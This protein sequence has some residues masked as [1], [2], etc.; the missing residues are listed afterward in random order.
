VTLA[1]NASRFVSKFPEVLTAREPAYAQ[2]G[3]LI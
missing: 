3:V 1:R 2:Y